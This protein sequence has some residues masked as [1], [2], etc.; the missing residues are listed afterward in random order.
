M[1]QISGI[2][3]ILAMDSFKNPITGSMTTSLLV[4]AG[5]MMVGLLLSIGLEE[6]PLLKG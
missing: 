6:S 3:F 4:L 2:L 1:G 5:L